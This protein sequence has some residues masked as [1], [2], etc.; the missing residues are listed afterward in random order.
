MGGVVVEGGLDLSTFG[1]SDEMAW[2]RARQKR[3]GSVTYQNAR[4]IALR[5]YVLSVPPRLARST[6]T[7]GVVV[8]GG[9]DLSTLGHNDEM[10]W[11]RASRQHGALS[12]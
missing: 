11:G 10:A 12:F 2:G 6:G 5:R 9:L 1:H 7:G 3:G 8:G 4:L